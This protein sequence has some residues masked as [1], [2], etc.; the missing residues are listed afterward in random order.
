M[1]TIYLAQDF[2]LERKLDSHGGH[3]ESVETAASCAWPLQ[4]MGVTYL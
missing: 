3:K 4:C 2:N 1:G